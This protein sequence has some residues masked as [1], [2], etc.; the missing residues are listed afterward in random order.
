MIEVIG[1]REGTLF[2]SDGTFFEVLKFQHHRVAMAD[3]ICRIKMKNL[4][5]GAITERTYRPN[6]RFKEVEVEK[7]MKTFLYFDGD[8][9]YFMDQENFEQ[10]AF[11]KSKLG[12]IVQFLT[13]NLE[14]EAV[15]GSGQLLDFILPPSIALKVV[16]APPGLRGD[17][18]SNPMKPI[19]LEN[20]MTI[21]APLFIKDGDVVRVN[22][23]TGQYLERAK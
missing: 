18:V 12:N 9:G 1:F 16:S 15:Y 6:Q 2:E 8:L 5:T 7:R 13:E 11:P 20:G 17:S 14:V 4:T 21:Q 3:A 19:V 23:E 22:T 10:V